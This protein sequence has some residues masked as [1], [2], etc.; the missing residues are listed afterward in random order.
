[1]EKY[2]AIKIKNP[3]KKTQKNQPKKHFLFYFHPINF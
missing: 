2:N 3:L 1:M